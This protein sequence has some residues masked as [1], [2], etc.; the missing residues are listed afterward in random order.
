VG[1][2]FKPFVYTVAIDNGYSPVYELL[3]QPVTIMMPDGKRWTP[4]NF[5][6]S[7]GGRSTIREAIKH[8]INLVAVRAILEIAPVD[9]V[10]GYA[11]RMGI[12]SPLPAV[13][14][15]ALGVGEVSPLEMAAAFSVFADRGVH[16]EP[17][18]IARIED[19][20]GTVQAAACA[21]TSSCLPPGRPGRLRILRMHGS[22][23]TPRG[24]QRRSGWGLTNRACISQRGTVRGGGPPP[25]YGAAS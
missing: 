11:K 9:Q 7:F 10:I 19:K 14:S 21:T 15:L 25:P 4:S 8:S 16:V 2:A 3:N 13:A 23:D 5:D 6:G 24:S 12:T 18:S 22:W 20:D 1:S 17:L